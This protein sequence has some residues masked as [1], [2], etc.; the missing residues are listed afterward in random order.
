MKVAMVALARRGG[1]VH[2]VTELANAVSRITP[3]VVVSSSSAAGALALRRA[4]TVIPADTGRNALGSLA[5]ALNPVTWLTLYKR[6][7]GEKVDVIHLAGVHEWNPML[8]MLGKM[9]HRP[10]AYTIH[11][12]EP[13]PGAP[14]LMRIS[15][16][17]TL[18]MSDAIVVLT[19][20]GR[21]RLL[22]ARIPEEKINH[23][24]HGI[25]SSFQRRFPA[26]NSARPEKL[27]LYLGRIEP[28]KGVD[29][30]IPA[31]AHVRE[32]LPDWTLVVAGAGQLP[33]SLA[34]PDV[35]G[36]EFLHGF[37]PD[38]EVAR[39]MRM[40]RFVVLPY[41]SATQSGVIAMSYAFGRPVIAT[42]VGG[43]REMVLPGKTGLLVPPNDV[44]ALARAMKLLATDA[45]VYSRMCR[46]VRGLTRGPWGPDKIAR[47]H[48][49]MYRSLLRAR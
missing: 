9:L 13:H 27:I 15:N 6:L 20:Q 16:W 21:Q 44:Q 31:F 37:I 2:F 41:T 49:R 5:Q 24:P 3:T 12:P 38:A 7:S 42:E 1:M 46:H 32:N 35:R 39:L 34:K 19:E 48:V 8:C 23:I 47:A 14:V 17:L 22:A 45:R 30:L 18:R 43:L 25:Y 11:D 10:L 29:I 4:I 26:K 28:Y 33:P 36:L 40:S